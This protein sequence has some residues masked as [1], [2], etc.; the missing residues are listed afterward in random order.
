MPPAGSVWDI[1]E[2]WSES[3]KFQLMPT[4]GGVIDHNVQIA[5]AVN[6]PGE[7]EARGVMPR[8]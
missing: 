1:T 7:E 3:R 8:A 4:C 2:Y 6:I 5:V